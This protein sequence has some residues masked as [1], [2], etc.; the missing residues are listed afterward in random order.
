MKYSIDFLPD[1]RL[2]NIANALLG[3]SLFI[4]TAIYITITMIRLARKGERALIVDAVNHVILDPETKEIM[5]DMNKDGIIRDHE[6][7]EVLCV[8]DWETNTFHDPDGN[9]TDFHQLDLAWRKRRQERVD[10]H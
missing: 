1:S 4:G 10:K 2:Y 8:F 6:T 7:G 9:K 5:F 3:I